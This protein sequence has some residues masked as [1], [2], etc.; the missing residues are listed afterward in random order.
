MRTFST[1]ERPLKLIILCSCWRTFATPQLLIK[2][3]QRG[4]QK[5]VTGGSARGARHAL[6]SAGGGAPLNV[7]ARK[8]R[9]TPATVDIDPPL[10]TWG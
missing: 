2:L 4:G 10:S 7:V 6:H 8:Q 1:L 9:R 5:G 3:T